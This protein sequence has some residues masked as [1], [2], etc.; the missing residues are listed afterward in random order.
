MKPVYSDGIFF[1]KKNIQLTFYNSKNLTGYIYFP[2]YGD[3]LIRTTA[4]SSVCSGQ[5]SPYYLQYINVTFIIQGGC[6]FHRRVET[7][8]GSIH[9]DTIVP[10]SLNCVRNAS[11]CLGQWFSPLVIKYVIG[12][13]PSS[14]AMW[15]AVNVPT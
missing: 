15:S 12:D 2:V 11:M 10:L 6:D 5:V 14:N 4:L 9:T 1:F 13:K 7:T 3:H 8:F